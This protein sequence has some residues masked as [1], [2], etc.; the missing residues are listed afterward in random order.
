MTKLAKFVGVTTPVSDL[1]RAI[2]NQ[3][4]QLGQVKFD[5]KL[6]AYTAEAISPHDESL[7]KTGPDEATAV[8]NA[9]L[10]VTRRNHMRTTAMYRVGMWRTNWPE[11]QREIAE[12]YRDAPIYD[13]KA[14]AAYKALADDS[15]HRLHVLGGQLH[16]EPTNEPH[17]YKDADEMRKDVHEKRHYSLSRAGQSHP[18][19]T[20]DQVAAFRAVHDILG[21]GVAGGGYDWPGRVLAAHAHAPLLEPIAQQALFS[22]A[23]ARPAFLQVYGNGPQ[24]VALFPEFVEGSQ[25]ANNPSAHRGIHP[26][27]V[28]APG[29]STEGFDPL[30]K[31][32][33]LTRTKLL[34]MAQGL[35]EDQSDVV[36]QYP[37]GWSVRKLNTYGDMHREGTLMSNC[38]TP[39][40]EAGGNHIWD[41]HPTHGNEF[42]ID[43]VQDDA[44]AHPLPGPDKM[45][46]LYSLRDEYNLPHVSIDPNED[47]MRMTFGRHNSIPRPEHLDRLRQW[48]KAGMLGRETDADWS[49]GRPLNEIHLQGR[50]AAWA[51]TL[52]VNKGYDSGIEPLPYNAYIHHGDPL[53]YKPTMD[54]AALVDTGWEKF[55]KGDGSDDRERMKQAIVN[56][57]RAVLLSPR[58]DL[59]WNA[60]HY[61]DISNIPGGVDDPKVYWDTLERSRRKWNTAQGIDEEAHMVYYP[62]LKPFEA[63]IAA[64]HP[65]KGWEWAKATAKQDLFDMWTEEQERIMEDDSKK[66]PDKQ[67]G[68]DE[69]ERRANE[70]LARRLKEFLK[71]K[72]DKTDV[73]DGQLSMLAATEDDIL[74]ML[75]GDNGYNPGPPAR[76]PKSEYELQLEKRRA[77]ERE[78]YERDPQAYYHQLWGGE[79]DVTHPYHSQYVEWVPIQHVLPY[80]EWKRNPAHG[81]EGEAA[82]TAYWNTLKDHMAEHGFKNPIVLD[83]HK[84]DSTGHISEGN[85]RL[86]VAHELGMT[87]VPLTVWPSRRRGNIQV[88]VPGYDY[89]GVH[90]FDERLR[91]SQ[92]GFPV[93]KTAA[94]GQYNLLTGEESLKYGA[95][96][97]THLKAIAQISQHADEIL[98]AALE[99]VRQHDGE[100]HHFRQSVLRLGVSGV[101]PKVCSFA[102]LL[103]QPLT[104]QLATIDTHMMDV[105]GHDYEKE[106]NNR[107]YF[108]FEREFRAGLDAAGYSHLPLGAG[109]WGMW[110]YKRTG[111]GSHQDHS[112]M[113]V[114]DPKPHNEVDW[115]GKAVNLKGESWHKQAPD[116]WRNTQPARDLVAKEWDDTYGKEFAQNKIPY[117]GLTTTAALFVDE[118]GTHQIPDSGI[119]RLPIEEIKAGM[120]VRPTWGN[121]PFERVTEDARYDHTYD[122]G[123]DQIPMWLIPYAR[124]LSPHTPEGTLYEVAPSHTASTKRSYADP[125]SHY[126]DRA[127]PVGSNLEGKA[128]T[129]AEYAKADKLSEDDYEDWLNDHKKDTKLSDTEFKRFKKKS[130]R[131]FERLS[132]TATQGINAGPIASI[133]HPETQETSSGMPGQSIMEHAR[134]Q[135]GLSTQDVWRLLGDEHVKKG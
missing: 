56:A 105:L 94:G 72:D 85:H 70:A 5:D 49:H 7:T 110:D 25:E 131:K 134:L 4:W 54:N 48:D 75:V 91:P 112:A 125:F 74:K 109:Q 107:D 1:A 42:P 14:V 2:Q 8:S 124:K 115:V 16:I 29:A 120:L 122:S 61:Q 6:N 19:W 67:K 13:P 62:F 41:L 53:Q 95:F 129:L 133:I 59:R 101:G 117:Q 116:W 12:A 57:F 123:G 28:T 119:T 118:S 3:G 78:L 103:L 92:V 81:A 30:D 88:P 73:E 11:R 77:E 33:G 113:R 20:S 17:P 114:L 66:P 89:A 23:V 24:K 104:S 50:T 22:E 121:F 127:M 18:V 76:K 34:Q 100:G 60:I 64:D 126:W 27:Q 51:D 68:A 37:D 36:H 38:F 71:P 35:P 46:P 84:D 97:G 111:P 52:D 86:A 39:A 83:V 80:A 69:I 108:K 93:Q 102:W 55:A 9:L 58:K 82:Q 132:K 90:K 106:M 10:A 79:G 87:H 96:M 65:E 26:S 44:L 47:T 15:M 135:Y 128:K 130:L 21:H 32:A 45:A 98:D 31:T 99:D 40:G 43:Q 63:R